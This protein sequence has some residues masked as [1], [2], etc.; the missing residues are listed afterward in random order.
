MTVPP[1]WQA[2]L[3]LRSPQAK[4][5]PLVVGAQ[6]QA[7]TLPRHPHK[8]ESSSISHFA[9]VETAVW[10]KWVLSDSEDLPR[11]FCGHSS[12]GRGGRDVSQRTEWSSQQAR[13]P[14][15]WARLRGAGGGR[16]WRWQQEVLLGL[17]LRL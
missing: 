3:A 7:A 5:R 1:C 10:W 14:A 8:G 16:G 11:K 9:T 2:G 15:T 13:W 12:S 17:R 6:A 4:H